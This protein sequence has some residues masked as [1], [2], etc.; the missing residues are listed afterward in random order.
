[1]VLL[2]SWTM[3]CVTCH[4]GDGLVRQD[5]SSTNPSWLGLMPWLSCVCHMMALDLLHDLPLH[6]IQADRAVFLLAVKFWIPETLECPPPQSRSEQCLQRCR[7]LPCTVCCD[8]WFPFPTSRMVF[9]VR[10]FVFCILPEELD[11]IPSTQFILQ[12]E[13]WV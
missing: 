12:L 9:S 10:Y 1:M 5:L 3:N 8:R 13:G 6:Q 7:G 2:V 11:C 4:G